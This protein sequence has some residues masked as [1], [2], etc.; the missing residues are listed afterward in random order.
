MKMTIRAV[1]LCAGLLANAVTAASAAETSCVDV[2]T[3]ANARFER[4]VEKARHVVMA[5]NVGSVAAV[6]GGAAC[7]YYTKSILG[8]LVL[9]APTA[10]APQYFK[11]EVVEKIQK[12]EDHNFIFSVYRDLKKGEM[13]S[14]VVRE[15][16]AEF[17]KP[18]EDEEAIANKLVTLME[19]G[20]LCAQGRPTARR[21]DLIDRIHLQIYGP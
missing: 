19:T 16:M 20:K 13:D 21:G 12:L 17:Q 10:G 18:V 3:R 5:L 7:A 6:A 8:C 1:G 15:F 4:E 14:E 2:Y 9:L 11:Q